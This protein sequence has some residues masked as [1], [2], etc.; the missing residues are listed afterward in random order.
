MAQ[1]GSLS[2]HP[3]VSMKRFVIILAVITSLIL[4]GS[5]TG[6]A[7]AVGDGLLFYVRVARL[8]TKDPPA[9]IKMPL[10]GV[11]KKQIANTWHAPRGAHR[12]HEGQDIFAQRGTA[13]Y[14]ATN[15]YVY[16]IGEN[17]LGGQT[18]S[19]IGAGGRVYYYAHLDSYAEGLAEGDY[20]T[21]Q[22]KLGEVGT[23]GNAQGTPPHLH[24]GVYTPSGAINPLPL[25]ESPKSKVPSP[26]SQAQ[27]PRSATQHL[28]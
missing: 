5:V 9:K 7:R 15:G 21:P 24:F 1:P 14:S 11:S 3:N 27:S 18:V 12:L 22:T 13:V 16:N 23:T 20:V 6:I 2:G 25:L 26:R 8:Y 19:V 4:V 10:P 17:P 28:D